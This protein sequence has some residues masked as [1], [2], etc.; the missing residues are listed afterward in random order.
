MVQCNLN[1]SECELAA[2]KHK[3]ILVDVIGHEPGDGMLAFSGRQ[4]VTIEFGEYLI[5]FVN[6]CGEH[7]HVGRKILSNKPS[8]VLDI[9]DS[10]SLENNLRLTSRLIDMDSKAVLAFAGYDR[11]LAT[12]HS[13]DYVTLGEMMGF[14]ATVIDESEE[15]FSRLYTKQASMPDLKPHLAQ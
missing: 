12:G 6:Y 11:L 1:C 15:S 14:P 3:N 2:G 13:L 9:V 10:M 8:V 5:C 4:S 7:V